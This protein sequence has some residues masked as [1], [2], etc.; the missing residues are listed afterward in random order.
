MKLRL[1]RNQ[2]R[3]SVEDPVGLV[4]RLLDVYVST[5]D[6]T[7]NG[8]R[9]VVQED[10]CVHKWGMYTG[11]CMIIRWDSWYTYQQS[12]YSHKKPFYPVLSF[13]NVLTNRYLNQGYGKTQ[14]ISKGEKHTWDRFL[15]TF[16]WIECLPWVSG[17]CLNQNRYIFSSTSSNFSSDSM[18]ANSPEK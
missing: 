4:A 5:L 11:F 7:E 18:H 1:N 10:C 3:V 6:F 15:W 2:G 9:Y 14:S 17:S 16:S 13:H 12:F 8:R